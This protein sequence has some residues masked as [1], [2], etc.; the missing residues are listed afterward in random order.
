M[1]EIKF[2][3]ELV[4]AGRSVEAFG[5]ARS[6]FV[7][8]TAIWVYFTLQPSGLRHFFGYHVF[9]FV[10]VDFGEASLLGD[11]NLTAPRKLEL[12]SV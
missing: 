6:P 10:C 7:Q 9:K 1:A 2:T 11:V 3:D 12:G 4:E 8:V 5:N